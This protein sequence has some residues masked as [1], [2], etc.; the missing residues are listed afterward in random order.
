V[1]I[2]VIFN[3]NWSFPTYFSDTN[4]D[5][6]W[7]IVTGNDEVIYEISRRILNPLW[8]KNIWSWFEKYVGNDQFM[9][10]IARICTQW[11]IGWLEVRKVILPNFIFEIFVRWSIPQLRKNHNIKHLVT[12]QFSGTGLQSENFGG[13][14]NLLLLW[15]GQLWKQIS[16]SSV[17]ILFSIYILIRKAF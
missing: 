1:Q 12:C 10:K 8:T 9:M 6:I 3:I 2:F 17:G 4:F 13:A 14:A 15:K 11:E 5:K 7:P 16:R